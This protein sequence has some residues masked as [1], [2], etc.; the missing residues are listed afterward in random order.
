MRIRPPRLLLA[1][2]LAPEALAQGDGTFRSPF[3]VANAGRPGPATVHAGDLN[4]DGKLDLVT[5]NG[6]PRILVYFQSPASREEWRQI[7]LPVGSQVWFVRASDFT[8]DG[9]DSRPRR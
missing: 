5:A 4:G 2:F 1:L 9:R 6:S 8:G 7:P 3:V